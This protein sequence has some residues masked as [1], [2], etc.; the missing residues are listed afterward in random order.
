MRSEWCKI[1]MFWDLNDVRSELN[2]FFPCSAVCAQCTNHKNPRKD[3]NLTIQKWSRY[4]LGSCENK[5]EQNQQQDPQTAKG[6]GGVTNPNTPPLSEGYGVAAL[7]NCVK[8]LWVKFQRPL[9]AQYWI[10]LD[11][12]TSGWVTSARWS[13]IIPQ[14]EGEKFGKSWRFPTTWLQELRGS[15]KLD[16]L[17][18]CIHQI[19]QTK[20]SLFTLEADSE[21]QIWCVQ[22][23][24]RTLANADGV[25]GL[26][27][28]SH[29]NPIFS[30]RSAACAPRT[31]R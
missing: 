9:N 24:H 25:D 13:G 19:I 2:D 16:S 18:T 15:S 23:A 3:A 10:F 1:W 4:T 28:V 7:W 20:K 27:L 30:F 5:R 6:T 29:S 26:P 8:P 12:M 31:R 22:I 11:A 21:C 17:W 14:L